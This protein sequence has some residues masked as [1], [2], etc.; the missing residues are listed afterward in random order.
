MPMN[1]HSHT[2][3]DDELIRYSRHILMPE[4][5]V[6]GQRRIRDSHALIIG[7]GGLGSPVIQYLAA[8]GIGTLSIIDDDQVE[9]SNLQR[10][11]IHNTSTVSLNKAESAHQFVKQL[12]NDVSVITH[13]HR[14]NDEELTRAIK[15]ADVVLDCSDNFATRFQI[16]RVCYAEKTSLITAAVIRFEGQ[17]CSFDFRATETACYRCLYDDNGEETLSCSEAG[18]LSSAPGVMGSL[19]ASEALKL[20]LQLPT[21]NNQMLLVDLLNM[22]FRRVNFSK[23]PNCPVCGK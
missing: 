16:N 23:D 14:L 4:I 15:N 20:I 18:V 3:N 11:T 5:D 7:A 22:D 2:D 8:A 10:Q 1:P 21:L 12:N 9:L 19:Q 17:L 13:N 6:A